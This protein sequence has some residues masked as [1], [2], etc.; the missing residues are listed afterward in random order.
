[1]IGKAISHY[2][3][4]E[5]LGAGGMG[6]VYKAEDTKLKRTVALKF[7]PDDLTRNDEAKERFVLEAQAASALDHPNICNIYEIDETEPA[8]GEP[9]GQLFIAMACYEGETLKQK[10]AEGPLSVDDAVETAIQVA[11]GLAKAHEKG[12]VHRDIKPAN[13]MI[14]NDGVVKI[15]DF[16]LAKLSGATQLTKTGTTLGT[17]AYMSP[18]QAQGVEVDHR[19]DIWALGIILYEM[20]SGQHPFKGD[21][22]QAV[23][24][25][26]LS[27]EPEPLSNLPAELEQ[28][29]QKA[30]QKER[31]ERYQSAEELLSDL[32]AF[33]EG[34]KPT[35][36]TTKRAKPRR[37]KQL[38][39]VSGLVILLLLTLV[40]I[41]MFWPSTQSPQRP[42]LVVLPFENLGAPEDEYFAE[43]I[44]EE[45][46][47]RLAGISGLQIIARQSASRY[48][49]TVKGA[50]EIA[51]EL[52]VGY[53][54]GGTIR[55]QRLTDGSSRVRVIPALI[56]VTDEI[57]LWAQIYQEDLADIFEVQSVIA[58]QV[59]R[60][61]G[62]TLLEPEGHALGTRPTENLQA[63]N[64]YLLGRYYWN[65]YN[66]EEAAQHFN[67]ALQHD[68]NFALALS[69]L[70]EALVPPPTQAHGNPVA[71]RDIAAAEQA[72]RRAVKLD[73]RRAAVHTAL[74]SVL[75]FAKWDWQGAEQAL[76]TAIDLDPDYAP[77]HHYYSF[78]LMAMGR[79]DDA[80]A[81]A[82]RAYKLDP[83]SPLFA[84]SVGV[85]FY[86][87]RH[88][89]EAV[90]W[91]KRAL[92][93]DPG[94]SR[95]HANLGD[96]YLQ[97][98]RFDE[99]IAEYVSAGYRLQLVRIY[100]GGVADST[101]TENALAI[102]KQVEPQFAE[103]PWQIAAVYAR[104]GD[105]DKAFEWLDKALDSRVLQAP[106]TRLNPVW[107]NLHSDRR[108]TALLEKM[109]LEN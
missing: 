107:D 91:Y 26:I 61:L 70:A 41:L 10:L 37:Q 84:G 72:A 98:S 105:T 75:L 57:Q 67:E 21:Y 32:Q 97:Q 50:R 101:K 76:A 47:A 106:N 53:V 109:G 56:R 62:V 103:Q 81:A 54:L 99:A 14:T 27:E 49:D 34:G 6:V 66:F 95:E 42:R 51:E 4:L 102:I 9:G 2:K 60:A 11:Q 12:I 29:V 15:L 23:I 65:R 90:E 96:V 46:T 39:L 18:E 69:G 13:I 108:F 100:V 63:Y 85:R 7:L 79:A 71:I 19:T 86:V 28:I 59:T 24:Y 38:Y 74:G 88:Y 20:L 77:A 68:P 25:S 1:M 80:I 94:F 48:K 5:K 22:E 30:L 83:V 8:P 82:L 36:S 104:L 78:Y 87:A 33:Q 31:D 64:S 73:S 55:W 43:G 45:I 89:D 3:I 40:G 52:G 92:E 16:G 58:K 44:T 35:A 93:L 17:L